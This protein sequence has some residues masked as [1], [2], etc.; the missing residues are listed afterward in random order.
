MEYSVQADAAFCF[1]CRKFRSACGAN[2]DSTFTLKGYRNWKHAIES[3]KGFHKHATSKEHLMCDAIWREREKRT[4]TD[5][6][7][8]TLV[9]TEQLGRNRYYV[10]SIVDI[11]EFLAT[12]Q[13]PLRG[14]LDAFGTMSEG[15]SGLFLSLFEYTLRKDTQL[16]KIIKTIPHNANYTSH[17]IQNQLIE[18]MSSVV[19]DAIVNDIGTHWFTIK[20]D[21]TRDP[22]GCENISIVIRFISE[23]SKEVTERLLTMA[24]AEAGDA[25]TLTD[26]ILQELATAGLSS[27]KILSQCYD[28]ASVMSGKHGGVQKLLQNKLD[29]EIPY[30]HCF[31]HQL[32]LVVVH[33]L[34]AESA[35]GDFFDVCGMLFNFFRKPTVSVHYK[36]DSLKRLLD[37]RWSGHLATVSVIL[38]NME[39]ISA[40]LSEVNSTRAYGSEV[41]VEAI[42]LLQHIQEPN[43]VFIGHAVHKILLLLDAPNKQLQAEEMD[44]LTGVKLVRS[45]TECVRELRCDTVFSEL[46]NA[47]TNNNETSQPNKRRRTMN[48]NLEQYVVEESV[49]QNDTNNKTELKRLYFGAI[50]TVLGE[51]EVRFS[52]RNGKLITALA[53][54]DPEDESFLDATKVK[55]ILDLAGVEMVQSEYCVARRFL[56]SQM[57]EASEEKWTVQKLLSK[58][59]KTL[60]AMPTVLLAL[61]LALVFGASTAT[62]E[63]SFSTLKGVFTDRRRSMLHARKARLVQLAF[64]KDLTKKCRNEWKDAVLRKFHSGHSRRL[65]LCLY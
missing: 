42:G 24:T 51:M 25:A 58:H 59:H 28:G 37:Q 46:W 49:G 13:L 21:G 23:G 36:G 27:E 60:E 11:V 9:N 43:F 54:L 63:N 10:S 14:K 26:T 22:T 38:K 50:D 32:H 17:D 16:A 62:C 8:S 1:P 48:R 4:E 15:G 45:A 20:V 7:I 47:A 41:R 40:V 53:A 35:I 44:L 30:V 12:N 34:S 39:D 65:Q 64:E 31:N 61:R 33:A 29:R 56:Q 6:E 52:E 55:P 19:T 57:E 3:N 18:A 5:T 2:V